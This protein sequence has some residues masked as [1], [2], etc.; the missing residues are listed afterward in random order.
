M[1]KLRKMMS[2]SEIN[3]KESTLSW[4]EISTPLHE[5]SIGDIA[6]LFRKIED[7]EIDKQI[8]NLFNKSR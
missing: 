1:N 4:D 5:Y 8:E 3:S 6:P 7:T 2:Q